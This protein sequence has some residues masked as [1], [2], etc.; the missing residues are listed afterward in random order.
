M[1]SL[2]LWYE[3]IEGEKDLTSPSPAAQLHINWGKLPKTFRQTL[4]TWHLKSCCKFHVFERFIDIG[5]LIEDF[6][7]LQTVKFYFPFEFKNKE[8]QDLG[9][10][11]SEDGKLLSALFNEYLTVNKDAITTVSL[12]CKEDEPLF[13]IYHL[14]E[15]FDVLPCEE[16]GVVLTI[17]MPN[18]SNVFPKEGPK[19]KRL[20]I[21]FRLK[22]T[23]LDKF[24]YSEPL[25]FSFVQSSFTKVSM[26][27]FRL[28]DIREIDS[29]VIE[30]YITR[31]NF[32]D[33]K[34]IHFFFLGNSR[35]E[36]VF[37]DKMSD[38]CRLLEEERWTAYLKGIQYDIKRK[39]L[40][41]HWKYKRDKEDEKI[42]KFNLLLKTTYTSIKVRDIVI[43]FLVLISLGICVN[44]VSHLLFP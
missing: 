3:K 13:Y 38:D 26:V 10:I 32:F 44:F 31:K 42:E 22:S 9:N 4:N 2:A 18:K 27:D 40:S 14:G 33:L 19:T 16:G 30:N 1:K 25:S 17:K 35:N 15:R 29:K 6:T 41:Y 39:V 43:Y 23:Q 7:S 28:N 24:C 5:I 34:K 36:N 21:R 20:Y 8:F 37:F 12:V 11:I